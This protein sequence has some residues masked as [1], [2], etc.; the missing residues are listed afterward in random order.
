MTLAI[1]FDSV[2][3]GE[4]FVLLAVVL[5]VVGPKNLPST[6]RK[7]GNYY[8]KFRRAAESFKRQLMEMDTELNNVIKDAEKEVESAVSIPDASEETPSDGADAYGR[9]FDSADYSGG[10]YMEEDYYGAGGYPGDA[11]PTDEPASPAAEG[12][13]AVADVGGSDPGVNDGDKTTAES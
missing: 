2:G 3:A 12:D 7:F 4:W 9:E 11:G 6:I 8:S 5:I 13:G 1:V 10:D